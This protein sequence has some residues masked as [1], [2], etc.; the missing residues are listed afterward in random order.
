MRDAHVPEELRSRPFTTAQAMPLGVSADPTGRFVARADLGYET[1]RLLIEYDGAFHG[2]SDAR[3]T[4]AARRSG[5]WAG[6]CS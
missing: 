6:P 3:M 2:N 1:E 4:A 5:P